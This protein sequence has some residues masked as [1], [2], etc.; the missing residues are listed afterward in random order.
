MDSDDEAANK[1]T[2]KLQNIEDHL[3]PDE[4]IVTGVNG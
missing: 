1:S 2:E 4:L 3:P